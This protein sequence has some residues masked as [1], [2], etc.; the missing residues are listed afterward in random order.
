MEVVTH[1]EKG[2][3]VKERHKDGI[4]YMVNEET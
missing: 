4:I 1:E 2:Y 3:I